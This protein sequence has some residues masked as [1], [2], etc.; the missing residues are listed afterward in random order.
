MPEKSLEE[1]TKAA[2]AEGKTVTNKESDI[3][4]DLEQMGETRHGEKKSRGVIGEEHPEG[5]STSHHQPPGHG[6]PGQPGHSGQG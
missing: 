1:R 5:R 4:P 2:K 3:E 6:H